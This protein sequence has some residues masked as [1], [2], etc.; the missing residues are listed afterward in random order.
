MEDFTANASRISSSSAS[1]NKTPPPLPDRSKSVGDIIQ[2]KKKVETQTPPAHDKER[3]PLGEHYAHLGK[4]VKEVRRRQQKTIASPKLSDFQVKKGDKIL[5]TQWVEFIEAWM[6]YIVA[7]AAYDE[8]DRPLEPFSLNTI[9]HDLDRLY[10]M[11]APFIKP[12][13]FVST[14]YRW[15]N[16]A[17]TGG[18]A[19]IYLILWWE[20]L[21]LASLCAAM[22][23]GI[24]WIRLDTFA[25]Y[26]VE[27]LEEQPETE[28]T[29]KSWN[30]N[31]WMKMRTTIGSPS[32]YGFNLFDNIDINIMEWRND[33]YTSYGPI[34]QVILSDTADYLERVK[35]LVT[36]KRPA[37][38]RLL[39]ALVA[40][41][42]LFLALLP[43][44]IL[45]KLLF[46]YIGFEFFVLQALRSHYPRHRRLFNVLNLL[47]WGIPNDA[48]YAFEVVRLEGNSNK[49]GSTTAAVVNTKKQ[50]IPVAMAF[51][52]NGRIGEGS[53]SSSSIN[54][55]TSR[56][57]VKK[58][59]AS[60]SDYSA[61]VI[62][63]VHDNSKSSDK[64]M[65]FQEAAT[66]TAT[67]FGMLLAAAAV[68]KV[69]TSIDS[70]KKKKISE[71]TDGNEVVENKVVSADKDPNAFG[72]MYKGNIPGRIMVRSN[73][74][75]FQTSRMTGGKI[76]VECA[77]SDIVGVKKT[78]QFDVVVWHSNGIDISISDGTTLHF[79]NVLRRDDCFNRLVSASGGDGGEWKK[80]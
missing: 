17:L 31:L 23:L 55:S 49:S 72:C 66:S 9:K 24:V 47:L 76:L 37:R 63:N 13:K 32:P 69:K 64:S 46:L 25:Q 26:G 40:S 2:V 21:I 75:V 52:N 28:A 38:T 44:Q 41:S 1:I 34:A 51:D 53:S 65:T 35:N 73:G 27:A 5:S 10:P 8:I 61:N 29:V 6:K 50:T 57:T 62:K 42:S 43:L 58:A 19:I 54:S 70:K 48:E 18:L 74:F 7:S 79:E 4:H 39:L 20:D 56:P 45:F 78:K 59:F 33:I 68:N 3:D 15:E 14:I 22:A 36:W 16:K 80:M 77:F 71:E 60:V 12:A 67:T 11:V 30:R